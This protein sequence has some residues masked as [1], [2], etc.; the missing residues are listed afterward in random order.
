MTP[1]Q[2]LTE[3]IT[4]AVIETVTVN[5]RNRIPED[6]NGRIKHYHRV[7]KGF[8]D[9]LRYRRQL[10]ERGTADPRAAEVI[11]QCCAEDLLFFVNS[12]VWTLS[13]KDCPSNPNVPMITWPYQ[14]MV[15]LEIEDAIYD[16]HALHM[17]KSRDMGATWMILV[18]FMWRALF[19]RGQNFG[20]ASKKQ[21]A[22]DQLGNED[23]LFAKVD[24]AA[25]Y[26]PK[27]LFPPIERKLL[28]IRIPENNSAMNG[29]STTGDSFRGGRRG[30]I[31]CDEMQTVENDMGFMASISAVTDTKIYN[32][33]PAG[34]SNEFYR[35]IA[36][37]K[38]RI[39]L[40]WWLHPLKTVGLY[41]NNGKRRSPWYDRK[42]EELHPMTVAQEIDMDF[43]GSVQRFFREEMLGPYIN[44]YAI[45]P[46][47][48][49]D[50]EFDAKTGA[51]KAM[52]ENPHGLWSFWQLPNERMEWADD[53][54]F[55]A[56]CDIAFG[57]GATN[58]TGV[59]ADA[60]DR[61]KIAEYANAHI[62]P[63]T[64][65]KL[66]VNVCRW[67]KGYQR[68]M[69]D[70][71]GG[72][73]LIWENNGGGGTSFGQ[74]VIRNGYM[75]VYRSR[76]ESIID[77]PTTNTAGWN[78]NATT[79]K[80]LLGDL[81]NAYA[82]EK[83]INPSQ[84]ALEEARQYVFVPSSQAIVHAESMNQPDPSGAGV[85]HGD[86]VIADGLVVIAFTELA[87]APTIEL[88]PPK[89]SYLEERAAA[90]RERAE[91]GLWSATSEFW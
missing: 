50:L 78:S 61:C 69:G 15:L 76:K 30:A 56:A 38:H 11:R 28:T 83:Y 73:F 10:I 66:M 41:W 49:G 8:H 36:R 23:C 25:R 27:W 37:T 9:N 33:T 71:Y 55:I 60:K 52:H 46:L 1:A 51:F 62:D 20:C 24:Y 44:K 18:V 59:I 42:C 54:A 86:R 3:I 12:F 6:W 70:E 21:D 77:R 80:L 7:P 13:P 87:D 47:W 19:Q 89:G 85:N 74:E 40:P 45:K 90:D 82:K 22:V 68:N 67:F 26:L 17:C 72:A 39:E 58:S 2:R 29:D 16:R 91:D 14:D 4:P 31:F 75:N 63:H 5:R 32:G 43:I 57:T 65:A 88:A 64:F 35:L 53:R 84:I 79:R 48:R 81:Y 34:M